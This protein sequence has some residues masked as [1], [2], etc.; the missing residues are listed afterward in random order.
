MKKK[1]LSILLLVLLIVALGTL[2]RGIA[3]GERCI[4]GL[5]PELIFVGITVLA[6]LIVMEKFWFPILL[7]IGLTAGFVGFYWWTVVAEGNEAGLAFAITIFGILLL[8]H[9]IVW[10]CTYIGGIDKI[11]KLKAFQDKVKKAYVYAVKTTQEIDI[12]AAKGQ[13]AVPKKPVSQGK[14]KLKDILAFLP[15]GYLTYFQ[16][17][18]EAS[19]RIEE[20][21]DKVKW[22]NETLRA[23][24]LWNKN[25]FSQGFIPEVPSE[26]NPMDIE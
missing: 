20:L 11:A 7:L 9:L 5:A 6:F 3:V 24:E 26:L 16:L 4:S 22:Y 13:V 8:I 21:R 1:V 15:L 14:I 19:K 12:K 18:Q 2:I 10:P 17:G 23:Y 25:W